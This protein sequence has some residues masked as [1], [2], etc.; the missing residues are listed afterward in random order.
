MKRKWRIG[1]VA[2]C[3]CT[4]LFVSLRSEPARAEGS[5][6]DFVRDNYTKHVHHIP[7]RDGVKLYTVV[8]EPKDTSQQYPMLMLRT[9]YSV[10]PYE[11]DRYKE[12]LGLNPHLE[13][14]GYI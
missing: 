3:I 4:G 11:K 5:R 14:E 6:A 8:Y 7:M 2:L 12:A 1:T 13:K 10:A 9:P